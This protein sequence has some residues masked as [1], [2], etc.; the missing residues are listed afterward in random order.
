MKRSHSLTL[1]LTLLLTLLLTLSI[2]VV[3]VGCDT[4]VDPSSSLTAGEGVSLAGEA[5]NDPVSPPQPIDD[6]EELFVPEAP[7][8]DEVAPAWPDGAALSFTSD[9]SDNALTVSWPEA[10]DEGGVEGGVEAYSVYLDGRMIQRLGAE[11]QSYALPL[12]SV[13]RHEVIVIASDAAQNRSEPLIGQHTSHDQSPPTWPESAQIMVSDLTASAVTAQ[14]TPAIDDV[15]VTAY[16]LRVR[17]AARES[18]ADVTVTRVEIDEQALHQ[19]QSRLL[20]LNPRTAYTLSVVAFDGA[21]NES[22][23]PL[24]VHFETRAEGGSTWGEGVTLVAT[25][26]GG[27]EVTLTWPEAQGD[28]EGLRY[29]VEENRVVVAHVETPT[30]RRADVSAPDTYSYAVWAIDGHGVVS[31]LPLQATLE[32]SDQSPPTWP[33]GAAVSVIEAGGAQVSLRWDEASDNHRVAHYR[34]SWGD[35]SR[36]VERPAITLDGLSAA[37]DDLVSVTAVDASGNETADQLTTSVRSADEIAP[38]WPADASLTLTWVEGGALEVRWPPALDHVGVVGYT[39]SRNTDAPEEVGLIN[40]HHY[41]SLSA[42]MDHVIRVTAYDA[43]GRRTERALQGTARRASA[44]APRWP[45]GASMLASNLTETGVRLAW[46]QASSL[47][48]ELTYTLQWGGESQSTEATSIQL[49]DLE[50][51]TEYTFTL[52]VT[53]RDGR[54]AV[55]DLTAQVKTPDY[56]SPS[57]PDLESLRVVEIGER[58]AVVSWSAA[59]DNVGVTGYELSVNEA[60]PLV[61]NASRTLWRLEDL[62]P[63]RAY[64]LRL[65]AVDAAG[66]RSAESA[67]LS[68]QTVDMT[69]PWWPHGATATLSVESLTSTE[70]TLSWPEAQDN[71]E[72]TS[73]LMQINDDAPR[74]LSADTT[75]TRIDQLAPWQ[76][77][78]FKVYARDAAGLVSP[79]LEAEILTPDNQAPAWPSGAALTPSL[80]ASTSLTI[81]WPEATDDV[82]VTG[83]HIYADGVR[84]SEV[85]ERHRTHQLEGLRPAHMTLIEVVAVDAAGNES[86]RLAL[87]A[88]TTDGGPPTWAETS[89]SW[90]SGLNHIVLEWPVAQDDVEVTGYRVIVDGAVKL[91][92][93]ERSALLEGLES[94][95]LYSVRVDA[96]DEANNWS[97]D[98][99]SAEIPTLERADLGFRRLSELEYT[100]AVAH[101]F[102]GVFGTDEDP[103]LYCDVARPET[104]ASYCGGAPNG[105]ESWVRVLTGDSGPWHG[106]GLLGAYPEERA[107]RG[108]HE[109]GGGFK[110]LDQRLF[111]EHIGVWTSTSGQMTQYYVDSDNARVTGD[112]PW[113][114]PKGGAPLAQW[115][116]CQDELGAAQDDPDGLLAYTRTC[117]GRFVD[118]FGPRAL[119]RPMTSDE[120]E[121][122]MS[123]FDEVPE[124]MP[125]RFEIERQL[126]CWLEVNQPR[127]ANPKPVPWVWTPEDEDW[128][129]QV[130]ESE[131]SA[132]HPTALHLEQAMVALVPVLM[133]APEFVYHIEVGD[134]D[135]ALT[136]HELASRL[137]FHFWKAPPD[138]ALRALADSGELLDE[139]TYAAEVNRL[140][141]DPRAEEGVRTFYQGYFWLESMPNHFM[142]AN[143]YLQA[144]EDWHPSDLRSLG[145]W[146]F[147]LFFFGDAAKDELSNLGHYFTRE[148]PGSYQE[149][150]TSNL[151][152]L[153]CQSPGNYQGCSGAGPFGMF[154]YKTGNCADLQECYERNWA[155]DTETGYVQGDTPVEIPEPN[156]YGLITRIGFLMHDTDKERPIR[157]GLKIRD[158]LLCDP[159]PP[160]ENC[161]VVRVPNLTG[162]CAQDGVVTSRECSHNSHCE[163]GQVCD[164]PFRKNNLTV[165]QV[166]EEITEQEGTSCATCHARW[167]NG[168]GHALGNYSSQGLYRPHEPMYSAE[169][170]WTWG[171]WV[172]SNDLR[173]QAEWP[174]YDTQGS[175]HFEG[176]LHSVEGAEELAELLANSGRLESCWAQQYFRYTMGRLETASDRPVIE[177]LADQL[178]SG[179]SLGEVFKGIALTEA[180]K[181]ISKPPHQLSSEDTP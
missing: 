63:G 178:R 155:L 79:T 64:T 95:H 73:Y 56:T 84:V 167:I 151:N 129:A 148:Q 81:T 44:E 17:D 19:T 181:S 115:R 35:Q 139:A 114:T 31:D 161:D 24:E 99:P 131:L 6:D 120:R 149:M 71:V 88:Q 15:G 59:T 124:D 173:P 135:G 113:S 86:P 140:F 54:Q 117:F 119:R 103:R 83:Y 146:Y 156:R 70:V 87:S 158:M 175:F 160:P 61:M 57:F 72:V 76:S 96:R 163:E 27:D 74:T 34:V 110:R 93:A 22:V 23:T 147:P 1:S 25:Q 162:L 125:E 75:S 132:M 39:I 180:F 107:L 29:R 8:R 62:A 47:S 105:F 12:L 104:R 13:G 68:L 137:S 26:S 16:E 116:R 150:F 55:T 157:R 142:G 53:D 169:N 165:R 18:D 143:E 50:P 85:E 2:M 21:G 152:F 97:D 153:E 5:P 38:T 98:G 36:Q 37:V 171:R 100:R 65:H 33:E 51:W 109:L 179:V 7:V 89:L 43:S 154:A 10:T 52:T 4:P 126:N 20:E 9:D 128:C 66:N 112:T 168:M 122:F 60:E 69:A 164:D 94:G 91:E 174:L 101:L 144:Q 80:L 3:S 106:Y 145:N 78:R 14:W 176:Q 102:Q 46:P 111:D 92:T 177:S 67:S 48:D 130:D 32:M 82:G 141:N 41:D 121:D 134:A 30:W 123:Y 58:F 108:E 133:S 136:A 166:V 118:T 172:I 40:I 11:A 42:E 159:I 45:S 127:W 170:E 77:Y 138:Q 49:S 28:S 90:Q